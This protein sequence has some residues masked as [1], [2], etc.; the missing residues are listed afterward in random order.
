MEKDRNLNANE[1]ILEEALRVNS[2]IQTPS[3]CQSV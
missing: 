3:K 2:A 1:N